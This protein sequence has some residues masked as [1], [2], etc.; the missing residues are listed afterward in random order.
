LLEA[1]AFGRP[2]SLI[3]HTFLFR[4]LDMWRNVF[5]MFG[6]MREQAGFGNIP[7]VDEL[8]RRMDRIVCTAV[9]SFDASP[10]PGWELVR[11]V[12]PVLEDEKIAVPVALPWSA[13]DATPLVLVSFSTGFEQRNL[14]KLQRTLD[15]IATLPIHAVVTT[16]GIVQPDE[17]SAPANALVVNYAAH[18]P[19]MARAAAVITHGGHGTA[20]RALRRGLPMVLLPGLAADQPYIAAQMQD[21]GVGRALAGD[22]DVETIRQA[23]A[24]VLSNPSYRRRARQR[25]TALAGLDG[26]TVAADELED[27]AAEVPMVPG[28]P[29]ERAAMAPSL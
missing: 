15:A 12:G 23:I 27:L 1:P 6:G 10:A 22:A 21:W 13:D 17:L 28:V 8:W 11:H 7:S 25:A 9:A 29:V 4:Q 16:G 26:A 2:A 20:M 14:A 19:L 18:E 3:L 24:D 5:S